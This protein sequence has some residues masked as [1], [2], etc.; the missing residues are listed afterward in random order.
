ITRDLFKTTQACAGMTGCRLQL[1]PY[2]CSLAGLSYNL[3]R[4]SLAS[5][6]VGE[7]FV[8]QALAFLGGLC[9]AV[10]GCK[11]IGFAHILRGVGGLERSFRKETAKVILISPPLLDRIN[12]LVRML[13]PSSLPLRVPPHHPIQDAASLFS[14]EFLG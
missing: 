3:V 10:E 2:P 14:Q 9:P 13:E 4:E 1:Q 6:H 12:H 7:P 8:A 5:H 11:Q